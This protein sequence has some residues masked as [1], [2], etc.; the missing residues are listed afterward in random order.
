LK[1]APAGDNEAYLVRRCKDNDPVAQ[2][3]LYDKYVERTMMLC[4]R[5]I[6]NAED[7]REALMDSFLKFF[8]QIKGFTYRGAG[9]VQAWL[10]QI[11]IN[12]CLMALRKRPAIAAPAEE[13]GDDKDIESDED[14]LGTLAVKDIMKMVQS[15]PDGYRTV[16]NLYVFDGLDHKEIGQLLGISEQTSKSQLHRAR[17]L[18]KKKMVQAS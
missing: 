4:L 14:I 18:L 12:Q 7:A 10:K 5:Y 9:G 11:A 13:P 3:A 15:L 8:Q 1:E 16:F 17:V 2:K 6:A